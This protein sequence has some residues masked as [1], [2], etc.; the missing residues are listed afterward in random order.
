MLKFLPL[1]Y[2]TITTNAILVIDRKTEGMFCLSETSIKWLKNKILPNQLTSLNFPLI[3]SI[4]SLTI[5]NTVIKLDYVNKFA[6]C[7]ETCG[8]SFKLCL[9]V[10]LGSGMQIQN[11]QRGLFKL[12]FME[13][14]GLYCECSDDTPNLVT[15]NY[16][17]YITCFNSSCLL[18]SKYFNVTMKELKWK[19]D[20]FAYRS[21][22]LSRLYY[23][24]TRQPKPIGNGYIMIGTTYINMTTDP[25]SQKTCVNFPN[26][27]PI[28]EEPEIIYSIFEPCAYEEVLL[29]ANFTAVR[30]VNNT[31]NISFVCE[32]IICDLLRN[33]TSEPTS[34]PSSVLTQQPTMSPI[35]NGVNGC[36]G[37][38]MIICLV[39]MISIQIVVIY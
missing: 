22:A 35:D 31:M 6:E 17:D 24:Q 9:D 15:Q 29:N 5:T 21:G 38:I 13:S 4:D 16:D 10:F 30:V 20:V 33:V 28:T 37:G 12:W 14:Q 7:S 1:V 23:S 34:G 39:S 27:F 2:L 8:I 25:I 3:K 18:F 19:N 32:P 36:Y 26:I 11:R